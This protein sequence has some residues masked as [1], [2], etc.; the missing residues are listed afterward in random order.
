MH[1]QNRKKMPKINNLS[2]PFRKPE[3]EKQIKFKVSRRKEVIEIITGINEI[4]NEKLVGKINK[5]KSYFFEK[6]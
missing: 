2:F 4:E 5:T 6:N 3:V 1:S